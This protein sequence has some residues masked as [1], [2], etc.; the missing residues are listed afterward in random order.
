MAA[1]APLSN[2]DSEPGWQ[3]AEPSRQGRQGRLAEEAPCWRGVRLRSWGDDE[4]RTVGIEPLR[5]GEETIGLKRASQGMLS[6][7][8]GGFL[9]DDGTSWRGWGG[10]CLMEAGPGQVGHLQGG[11]D[12]VPRDQGEICAPPAVR[13]FSSGLGIKPGAQEAFC[14]H[15][16]QSPKP[17]LPCPGLAAAFKVSPSAHPLP[18]QPT[19][20]GP[21]GPFLAAS[22][23]WSEPWAG[24]TCWGVVSRASSLVFPVQNPLPALRLSHQVRQWVFVPHLFTETVPFLGQTCPASTEPR[25]P[26]ALRVGTSPTTLALCR[27][28]NSPLF[29]V[30]LNPS[31]VRPQAG[32]GG[33]QQG[34]CP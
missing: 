8:V 26:Q 22:S 33:G 28:K 23:I 4:F 18:G 2:G 29:S 32:G 6:R 24:S 3:R 12:K 11:L 7:T 20:G 5:G 27:P 10:G 15:E 17:S 25:W 14:H 1:G 34:G 13:E 31:K 16:I 19:L 21:P 9:E 30:P